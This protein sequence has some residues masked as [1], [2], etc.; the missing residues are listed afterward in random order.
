M[1]SRQRR[2]ER[3]S[4]VLSSDR[5]KE[6]ANTSV[7]VA[8]ETAFDASSHRTNKINLPRRQAGADAGARG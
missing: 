2:R 4:P 6:I 5:L 3:C 1:K 7:G 8:T